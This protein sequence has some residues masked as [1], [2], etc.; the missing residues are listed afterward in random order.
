MKAD[1]LLIGRGLAGSTL[2]L[3]LVQ[4]GCSVIS[5]DNPAL[6]GSSRV[7]AGLVNPLVFRKITFSWRAIEALNQAIHFY[8]GIEISTGQKFFHQSGMYRIFGS[9]FEAGSW[10]K[11][12]HDPD[13]SDHLGKPGDF[14]QSPFIRAPFG[15]ALVKT[16]A[17]LET[18]AFLN[19]A[20]KILTAEATVVEDKFEPDEV[21]F[22]SEEVRY[23]EFSAKQ[24]ILCDGWRASE[25]KW[26]GNL[27]FRPAKGEV[28][29][30]KAHLL[31][32]VPFNGG[33]FGVP[34][35]ESLFRIGSTYEW[36]QSDETPTARQ[37]D[38][39]E[40][41]LSEL[42]L[43]PFEVQLHQA[44]IRPTV[45]DRRPLVGKHPFIDRLHLFNGLGTR[46]AMLAPLLA[47]EMIDFL[48]NKQPLSP[49][50]STGR[51]KK[52]HESKS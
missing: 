25:S 24:L 41:R 43:V 49:I 42:L 15:S 34:A 4:S 19:A 37:R 27:P 31:P 18:T 33:V 17:Y 12:M 50:Y 40:K 39:L 13:F 48:L 51:F 26:F 2:A 28:L 20:L 29:V 23:R 47:N 1:F 3:R 32:A 52:L 6:S 11:L 14:D 30:V 38:D 8:S 21:V 36:G 46:G 10:Q 44:G 7:A 16:A 9:E 5:I 22:S 35:G 45:S